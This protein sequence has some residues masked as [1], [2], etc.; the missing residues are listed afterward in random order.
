MK[1]AAVI[2]TTSPQGSLVQ[3][4]EHKITHSL[5]ALLKCKDRE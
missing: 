2:N 5:P 1:K 3:P 4:S